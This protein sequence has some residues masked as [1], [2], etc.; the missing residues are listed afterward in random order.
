MLEVLGSGGGGTVW[1]GRDELL[2]RRVALKQLRFPDAA[3]GEP[4]TGYARALAEAQ[5]AARVRSPN[6]VT[7]FDVLE[8]APGEI[9][10][11]LELLEGRSLQQRVRDD[12]PLGGQQ[13]AGV[14]VQLLDA[15]AAVHAV[16]VVHRDVKPA[17]VML[18]EDGRVVL[19]DFGIALGPGR[20]ALT[21]TG[22]IVGSAAYLA[23]ER[24]RGHAATS[25][26]DLWALGATLYFAAEG[27]PAFSGATEIDTLHAVL[28]AA[29]APMTG[30]DLGPVV[31]ALL[32][33]DPARRPALPEARSALLPLAAGA[34]VAPSPE[35]GLGAAADDAPTTVTP[36][37]PERALPAARRPRR[38]RWA[39]AA[40]VPLV[41]VAALT[42]TGLVVGEPGTPA[43]AG[44]TPEPRPTS[45]R[46][47][48]SQ[49]AS[50]SPEGR[51]VQA[52]PAAVASTTPASRPSTARTPDARRPS[53]APV[54]SGTNPPAAAPGPSAAGGAAA[55][56][57]KADAAARKAEKARERAVRAAE[58]AAERAAKAAERAA[59][60]REKAREKAREKDAEKPGKGG[61][62]GGGGRSV[63]SGGAK[64]G[65]GK[66]G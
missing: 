28:A 6:V 60:E 65:G 66:K 56:G 62:N 17:N 32:D 7:V 2:G 34:A 26:S 38:L 36:V 59:K 47:Q 29:P 51:T 3:T 61:G 44:T 25:G 42:A 64:G 49:S 39:L 24:A 50:A 20:A 9:W 4:G 63:G 11:V 58:K 31:H 43:V 18:L 37:L 14:G 45:S 23:P 15:L 57:G 21:A 33:A 10:L 27:R 5:A 40:A 48:A 52:V 22:T 1:A 55:A 12:G 19:T 13:A 16:D 35:A 53:S 30:S 46:P 54:G 8:P 41:A